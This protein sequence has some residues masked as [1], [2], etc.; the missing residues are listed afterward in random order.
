MHT[1]SLFLSALS[2]FMAGLL[3]DAPDPPPA[4]P[5]SVLVDDFEAYVPGGLPTRWKYL[6]EKKEV[7]FVEAQH[8][9]PNERFFIAEEEGNNGCDLFGAGAAFHNAGIDRSFL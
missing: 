5:G 8:M 6:D 3:R 1:L 4:F 9:R 7:V 2:L